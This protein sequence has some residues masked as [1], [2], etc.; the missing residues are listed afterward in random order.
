MTRVLI[1]TA[2]L[3]FYGGNRS[4]SNWARTEDDIQAA[5][6]SGGYSQLLQVRLYSKNNGGNPNGLVNV[7]S[8]TAAGVVMPYLYANGSV[9]LFPLSSG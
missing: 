6:A 5:L 9:C 1:Q 2:L 7:T 8:N 4:E 3:R